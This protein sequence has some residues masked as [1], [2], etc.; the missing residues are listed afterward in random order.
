[1]YENAVERP[2]IIFSKGYIRRRI[3]RELY[4]TVIYRGTHFFELS[5]YVGGGNSG[6]P[7]ILQSSIGLRQWQFIGIYIGEKSENKISEVNIERNV[8]YAVRA[9]AFASWRPTILDKTIKDEANSSLT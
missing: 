9:E 5:E 6:A 8:S 3:T 1:L 2:E 7:I 4:P